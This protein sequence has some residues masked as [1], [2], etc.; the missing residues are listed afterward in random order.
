M[1]LRNTC[2]VKERKVSSI[3]LGFGLQ[4]HPMR[5]FGLQ[6]LNIDLKFRS[7]SLLER[8]GFGNY[9]HMN[10]S[11]PLVSMGSPRDSI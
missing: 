3:S 7:E 9:Q 8:L 10:S 11:K 1:D 6:I 2:E 5:M 4:Q